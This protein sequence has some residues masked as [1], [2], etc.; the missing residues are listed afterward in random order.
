M[1]EFSDV[2]IK[3]FHQKISKVIDQD[4]RF[5][6]EFIKELEEKDV[7]ELNEYFHTVIK[8]HHKIFL[9]LV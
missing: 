4:L 8:S 7:V 1:S 2:D 5:I 3:G 9:I 6:F